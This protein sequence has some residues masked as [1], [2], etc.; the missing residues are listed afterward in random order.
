[1]SR[2][3]AALGTTHALVVHG[4][5]GLDE[6]SPL[7]RTTV[8]EVRDGRETTWTIDPADFQ[9]NGGTARDV[10]GGEPAENAALAIEL[11]SGRAARRHGCA[12]GGHAQRGRGD[13]R[14][15]SRG[16]VSGGDCGGSASLEER[17]GLAALDRLRA[18]T[19]RHRAADRS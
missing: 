8:I 13:L 4:A 17:C 15:W 9:L 11:L 10:E 14:G 16:D 7:G 6:I 5:P 19:A 18:A 3:L 12:L 1:M 2:T